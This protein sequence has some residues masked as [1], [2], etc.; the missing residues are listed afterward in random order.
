MNTESK[1]IK[2]IIADNSD[3][4]R[5]ELVMVVTPHIVKDNSQDVSEYENVYD[6]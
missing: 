6:L 4:T 5:E 1:K 3:K 2:V